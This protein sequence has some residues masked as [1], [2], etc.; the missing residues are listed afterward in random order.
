MKWYITFGQ[1]HV[2]R[3][4]GKTFDADC[5]A[6]ING[7]TPEQCDKMAF[8]LFDGKF[9]EHSNRIPP[10]EYYPRGLIEVNPNWAK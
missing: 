3:V 2:H 1:I 5:V 9:H 10:M 4:N 8:E 7:E 6:V